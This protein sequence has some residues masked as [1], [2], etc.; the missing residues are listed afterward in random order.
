[1]TV[2]INGIVFTMILIGSLALGYIMGH[3]EGMKKGK[4]LTLAVQ[5]EMRRRTK[6][7]NYE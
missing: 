7:E 2:H 6:E 4:D 5:A 3:R 1:M